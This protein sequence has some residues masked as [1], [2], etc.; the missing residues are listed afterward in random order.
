MELQADRTQS[1]LAAEKQRGHALTLTVSLGRLAV[2]A[3]LG[4]AALG[5]IFGAVVKRPGF[6]EGRFV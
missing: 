4:A 1:R 5:V 6:S 2:M 3:A